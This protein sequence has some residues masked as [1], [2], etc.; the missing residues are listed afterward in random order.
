LTLPEW[1]SCTN[2]E[3]YHLI[4]I[5]AHL[6]L[7][8]WKRLVWDAGRRAEAAA[9]SSHA[10]ATPSEVLL[11]WNGDDWVGWLD[12]GA[13]VRGKPAGGEPFIAPSTT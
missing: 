9:C 10:V 11:G 5:N 8:V 7:F 4:L 13:V 12:C 2:G 3:S 6:D 1:E